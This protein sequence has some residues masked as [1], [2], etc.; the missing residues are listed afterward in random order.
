MNQV[1]ATELEIIAGCL[2][3]IANYLREVKEQ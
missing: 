2:V 1:F 3:R